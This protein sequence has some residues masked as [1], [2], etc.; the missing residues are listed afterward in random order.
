[1]LTVVRV[2]HEPMDAEKNIKLKKASARAGSP[3][4]AALNSTM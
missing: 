1:M 2:L 4:Q 3:W